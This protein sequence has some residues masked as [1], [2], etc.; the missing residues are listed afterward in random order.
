MAVMGIEIN[1]IRVTEIEITIVKMNDPD[2]VGCSWKESDKMDSEYKVPTDLRYTRNHEW[3]RIEGSTG[4]VGVTDFA[5]A[6][7]GDITYIEFEAFEDD[8]IECKDIFATIEAVKS[9]EPCYI[10]ASGRVVELNYGLEDEPE[11]VNSDPFG[12]GWIVKIEIGD[13]EELKNLL[14][15]EEYKEHIEP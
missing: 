15:P 14:S 3:I 13:E 12:E 6:Q 7:L 5:Q 4:I 10:P 9:A 2:N 11:L 1:S 8:D